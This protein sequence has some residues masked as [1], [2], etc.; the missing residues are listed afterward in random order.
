MLH[1]D[2][3]RKANATQVNSGGELQRLMPRERQ[4]ILELHREMEGTANKGV[5]S[6]GRSSTMDPVE[7]I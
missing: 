7:R 2:E 6:H 5:A 3:A 4:N 1:L